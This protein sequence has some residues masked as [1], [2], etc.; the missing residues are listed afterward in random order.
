MRLYKTD[1]KTL[2]WI[3]LHYQYS[4]PRSRDN[5]RGG[6]YNRRYMITKLE[7]VRDSGNDSILDRARGLRIR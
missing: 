7:A 5:A 1:Q 3:W 6:L 2:L 4:D